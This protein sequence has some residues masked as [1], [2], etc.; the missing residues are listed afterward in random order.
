MLS[1]GAGTG[2]GAGVGAG[3][4][5]DVVS[6]GVVTDKGADGAETLP[7]ASKATTV[8]ERVPPAKSSVIWTEVL[9]EETTSVPL[10]YTR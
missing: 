8:K 3:V 7:A 10:T 1:T 9:L 5:A 2:A 4:G 6:E